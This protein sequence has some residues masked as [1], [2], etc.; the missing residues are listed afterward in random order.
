MH[1]FWI[2]ASIIMFSPVQELAANDIVIQE[3]RLGLT[4]A[5]A[6]SDD[7]RFAA[8]QQ[9]LG[10][11]A[12][13]D[14]ASGALLETLEGQPSHIL[15]DLAFSSDNR[16]V[17]YW[18]ASG[19]VVW[20]WLNRR[21]IW[22]SSE[23]S[24]LSAV[25]VDSTRRKIFL[26]EGDTLWQRSLED[27]K[28][29]SKVQL[30][31]AEI[32]TISLTDSGKL[33][34]VCRKTGLI[35]F[36]PESNEVTQRIDLNYP[37]K[38]IMGPE[39][40]TRN[41]ELARH[42]VVN[43]F[44]SGKSDRSGTRF[45]T[46]FE[47][48]DQPWLR[49][50]STDGRQTFEVHPSSVE[51]ISTSWF[52]DSGKLLSIKTDKGSGRKT[53]EAIDPSKPSETKALSIS[54]PR[55]VTITKLDTDRSGRLIAAATD[56]GWFCY[57]GNPENADSWK[58]REFPDVPLSRALSS[59]HPD[60]KTALYGSK[61]GAIHGITMEHGLQGKVQGEL[62]AEVT[63]VIAFPDGGMMASTKNDGFFLRA[64]QRPARAVDES[65][66]VFWKCG[67]FIVRNAP[68]AR[69]GNMQMEVIR[70]DGEILDSFT[71]EEELP[72]F[73]PVKP[74]IMHFDA[75][76]EKSRYRISEITPE[77]KCRVLHDSERLSEDALWA[78]AEDADTFLMISHPA[79]LHRVDAR[80]GKSTK[81]RDGLPRDINSIYLV[82]SGKSLLALCNDF[83]NPV[84]IPLDPE[85]PCIELPRTVADFGK[86]TA[87]WK[88]F[89]PNG[90]GVWIDSGLGILDDY[91][92]YAGL[93]DTESGKL[94]ARL[95]VHED[96]AAVVL[97]SDGRCDFNAAAAGL[98][99]RRKAGETTL[100][101]VEPSPEI[102]EVLA[103]Y[104]KAP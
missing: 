33:T 77:G 90:R 37:R 46:I 84:L 104:L 59:I 60:G 43:G 69:S 9:F 75:G 27:G 87:R 53:V 52:G 48:R 32:G 16:Y 10:E 57:E 49:T 68:G 35:L 55:G 66:E 26:G 22:S 81:L 18:C 15:M 25:A 50:F 93:W 31:E 82:P 94:V 5:V 8:T 41:P 13:W 45:L 64:G 62:Q 1:K 89:T 17:S 23:S 56:K 34:I 11:L 101:P 14:T 74:L 85:K 61:S 36:D 78:V 70:S 98:V 6:L 97:L 29:L 72:T 71:D 54:F 102:F 92:S 79:S 65:F 76:Y 2:V 44:A 19:V 30:G 42:T 83:K 40:I 91:E 24:R 80:S 38:P 73:H 103:P 28:E 12:V 20:D 67:D 47:S 88:G 4:N 58:L 39:S 21:V 7:G 51:R 3:T 95:R 100:S 63:E 86:S 96:G 99:K